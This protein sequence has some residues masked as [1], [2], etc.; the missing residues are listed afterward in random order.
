MESGETTLKYKI[1]LLGDGGVGKTSLV[2]RFVHNE[3][4]DKYMKTLGTNIYSKES[5]FYESGNPV[6]VVLQIWDMMGQRAFKSVIKSSLENTNGVFFVCDLTSLE[7]LNNLL[8]WI[9]ITFA[10]TKNVAFVFIGNKSDVDTIEFGYPALTALSGCFK[11]PSFLTSAKTGSNVEAAFQ[12]IAFLVYQKRFV[13]AKEGFDFNIVEGSIS[14]V[15][16]AEDIIINTFCRAIGGLETGMPVVQ[17]IYK[18]RN[19]DISQPTKKD[20]EVVIKHMMQ[21]LKMNNDPKQEEIAQ[22]FSTI[23]ASL[24]AERPIP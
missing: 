24:P 2:K 4:G 15:I 10:N 21:H 20:L 12:M 9:K 5:M 19:I 22:K 8:Y 16:M 6:K 3:F 14:P 1:T 11:S 7:T 17:G 23:L 13:P 18:E